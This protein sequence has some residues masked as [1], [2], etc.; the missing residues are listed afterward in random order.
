MQGKG[1]LVDY[2][3]IQATFLVPEECTFYCWKEDRVVSER[4]DK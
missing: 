1:G 3:V 2:C 4:K